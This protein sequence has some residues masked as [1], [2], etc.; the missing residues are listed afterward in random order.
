LRRF[1]TVPA[2]D[3]KTD[4]RT[5]TPTMASTGRNRIGNN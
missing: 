4:G 2:C 3:S 5:D 1:D